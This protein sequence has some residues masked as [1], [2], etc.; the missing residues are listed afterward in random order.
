MTDKKKFLRSS[1]RALTG[2]GITAA[3]AAGAFA[4][5]TFTPPNVVRDPR[6]IEVATTQ[7]GERS[8]VCAGAFAELGADPSQPDVATPTGDAT[9]ITLGD[10]QLSTLGAREGSAGVASGARVL[11]AAADQPIA[12][13]Q[14][15]QLS[16]PTLSG[17]VSSTCV[18][19]VNEQWLIG[20]GTGLGLT[21]TL[22]LGNASQVPA[23]VQISVFDEAG[24]V[25]SLQTA[26][27][28]V[29]PGA[30][31]TIS[32]NGYAPN[33]ARLA[34]RVTST[35]APV[36]ATLGVAQV[37]GIVPMGASAVTRQLRPEK[38]LVI[39]GL[40]NV[41]DH[42]HEAIATDTGPV[43][44][45]PVIVSALTP[46]A[47]EGVAT[48]SAI[49]AAGTETA[50]GTMDLSPRKLATLSVSSW[51]DDATA[52]V[53]RADVPVFAGA[54]GASNSGS[55]HDFAWFTPSPV[56]AANVATAAPVAPGA[57]LVI[58]N[59]GSEAAEV[60]LS[61]S[62]AH[63]VNVPAGAAVVVD[64]PGTVTLESSGPVH[65]ATR[66]LGSAVISGYP[67]MPRADRSSPLTV[68]AE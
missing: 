51:P 52:A 62:S 10:G 13:A 43:D 25:D 45:F 14:T 34:V 39:P 15:Q 17:L 35:G 9:V 53:I 6:A 8:V 36:A 4:L 47:K 26:G 54:Q 44:Q 60:K 63:T 49:N 16:S 11:S 48:V 12:A 38:E 50:L 20:G 5:A 55:K 59:T 67:V 21:T 7:A 27:V 57:S 24:E 18:E 58:A 64:A 30:Q 28:I 46:G 37:D 56:I 41:A 1:A 33:R 65:A 3:A 61:G 29:A 31:Q 66:V 2:L 23:T 32:L 19:A 40:G 22:S 42:N 68:Y